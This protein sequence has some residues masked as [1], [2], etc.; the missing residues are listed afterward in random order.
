MRYL[1]ILLIVFSFFSCSHDPEYYID[2]A[3]MPYWNQ[4]NYEAERLGFQIPDK[5]FM[6]VLMTHEELKKIY[7]KSVNGLCYRRKKTVTIYIKEELFKGNLLDYSKRVEATVFHELGHGIGREHNSLYYDSL[8]TFTHPT[9]GYT[10]EQSKIWPVSLL[11]TPNYYKDFID[12]SKREYYLRE[13]FG[14]E[15]WKERE[16]VRIINLS[17]EDYFTSVKEDMESFPEDYQD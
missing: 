11:T 16:G 5:S 14:L 10:K 12:G 4:F 3:L 13:L 1:V 8:Y 17:S 15:E 7:G 6:L 2:P 9:K